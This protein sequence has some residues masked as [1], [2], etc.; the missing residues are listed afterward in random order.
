MSF[1]EISSV[2][3]KDREGRRE[4]FAGEDKDKMS[5]IELKTVGEKGPEQIMDLGRFGEG[6]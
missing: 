5:E 6:Q 1:E 4:A 3:E 2:E